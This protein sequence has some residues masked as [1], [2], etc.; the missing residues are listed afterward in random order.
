LLRKIMSRYFLTF[1]FLEVWLNGSEPTIIR[2]SALGEQLSVRKGSRSELRYLIKDEIISIIIT[3][4][5]YAK[6]IM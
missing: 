1:L 6:L 3:A 2:R 4:I 5:F